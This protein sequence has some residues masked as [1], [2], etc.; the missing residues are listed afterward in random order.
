MNVAYAKTVS[1]KTVSYFRPDQDYTNV[2]KMERA[3]LLEATEQGST[4]AAY[5]V[6]QL[7]AVRGA[8]ATVEALHNKLQVCQKKEVPP[9][10]TIIPPEGVILANIPDEGYVVY[11]PNE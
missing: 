10:S 11:V 3:F 6:T 2:P 7:E 4:L 1:G 8:C 9:N 5:A